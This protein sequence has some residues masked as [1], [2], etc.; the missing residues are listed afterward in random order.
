M[1]ELNVEVTGGLWPERTFLLALSAEDALARRDREPDRLEAERGL[2][3][4]V[5]GAYEELARRFPDRIATLDATEPPERLAEEIRGRL[6][7]S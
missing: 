5:E 4:L 3:A 6:G 7:L 2:Q 1:L